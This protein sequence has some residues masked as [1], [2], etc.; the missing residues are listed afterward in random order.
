MRVSHWTDF[1]PTTSQID[2]FY[3]GVMGTPDLG[4]NSFNNRGRAFA[5]IAYR[6]AVTSAHNG[7]HHFLGMYTSIQGVAFENACVKSDC[8]TGYHHI[9]LNFSFPKPSFDNG[10]T[11]DSLKKWYEQSYRSTF[12]YASEINL[13]DATTSGADATYGANG[14]WAANTVGMDSITSTDR[15]QDMFV[16]RPTLVNPT[17]PDTWYDLWNHGAYANSGGGQQMFFT[18]IPMANPRFAL[19]S[20][21]VSPSGTASGAATT[22]WSSVPSSTISLSGRPWVGYVNTTATLG[23]VNG[24]GDTTI[25]Y[26][27]VGS[28]VLYIWG[29]TSG[30]PT[31]AEVLANSNSIGSTIT[32]TTGNTTIYLRIVY[33]VDSFSGSDTTTVTV[34]NNS[35]SDT[36]DVDVETI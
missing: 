26:D 6:L 32:S 18:G 36:F 11:G 29:K 12:M 22:S 30:Y 10:L 4:F 27:I 35:V 3:G 7:W 5:S 13:F 25:S 16:L 8:R 14:T 2:N 1:T 20:F 34:T 21:T 9:C 28:G 24:S 33:E 17:D 15:I 23:L 31:Q 19:N